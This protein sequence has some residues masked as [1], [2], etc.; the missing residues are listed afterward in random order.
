MSGHS[1]WSNIK[2]RKGA[3]DAKR[4]KVFTKLLRAIQLA[5]RDGGN[6]PEMNSTLRMAIDRAKSFNVPKD[7]IDRALKK[8]EGEQLEEITLDAIGPGGTQMIIECVSNNK[9]RTVPELRN[10][11]EKGGGKLAQDGAA[12]WAFTRAG[13]VVVELS[14]KTDKDELLLSLLDCEANDIRE[15][16]GSFVAIT[17]PTKFIQILKKIE[18]SGIPI[19]DSMLGWDINQKADINESDKEKVEKLSD[20]LDDHDDVQAVWSNI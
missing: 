13:L 11:V 19:A 15:E 8:N 7:T 10:I 1:K 14:E 9:K 2:H 17:D 3:Q 18:A 12:R 20:L 4:A 6:D 5:V 16:E